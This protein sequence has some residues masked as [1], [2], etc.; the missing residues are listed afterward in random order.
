MKIRFGDVDALGVGPAPP[1]VVAIA[2]TPTPAHHGDL[3]SCR[4]RDGMPLA[5]EH[6]Q[7]KPDTGAAYSVAGSAA[8]RAVV[9]MVG[10]STETTVRRRSQIG[11]ASCRER[12]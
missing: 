4:P 6:F 9:S 7:S 12:V 2:V 5:P 1:L 8:V 10:R 3:M 11:R